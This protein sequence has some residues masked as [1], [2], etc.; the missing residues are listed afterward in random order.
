MEIYKKIKIKHF[1]SVWYIFLLV[2]LSFLAYCIIRFVYQQE[3][4]ANSFALAVAIIFMSVLIAYFLLLKKQLLP[5][6][7]TY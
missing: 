1:S 2:L 7:M 4:S 3:F 5:V 6:K